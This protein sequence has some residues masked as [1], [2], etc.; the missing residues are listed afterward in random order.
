[1]L[2]LNFFITQYQRN[3]LFV[4][5]IEE[6]YHKAYETYN[7]YLNDQNVLD[8]SD[9]LFQ[10]K[11]LCDDPD[12]R[13]HIQGKFDLVCVDEYQDCNN[14][15]AELAAIFTEPDGSLVVVGDADQAI[16]GFQ[17]ANVNNILQF[18]QNYVNVRNVTLP[19][20]FRSRPQIVNMAKRLIEHNDN[21]IYKPMKAVREDI[22]NC[23]DIKGLY[24]FYNV[25]NH[26]KMTI[27]QWNQ[28]G[29]NYGDIAILGRTNGI[30]TDFYAELNG[31]VPCDYGNTKFFDR[32]EIKD[33]HAYMTYVDNDKDP[34]AFKRISKHLNGVGAKTVENI[35]GLFQANLTLK[36]ILDKPETRVSKKARA[37]LEEFDAVMTEIREESNAKKIMGQII[38]NTTIME[39][40]KEA[41]RK[42]NIE[43]ILQDT[44]EDI[45]LEEY[46]KELE[47]FEV[48][49]NLVTLSTFH[50]AK[51]NEWKRCIIVGVNEGLIPHFREDDITEERRCFYVG[52]TRAEDHLLLLYDKDREPSR[53]LN[54]CRMGAI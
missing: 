18:H 6:Q 40:I 44:D 34:V 17:G 30:L 50:K 46:F 3:K 19:D 24:G 39:A 52:M 36:E 15:Q 1:M 23:V 53:F 43:K 48:D 27:A 14:L 4:E 5:P 49:S 41:P 42:S 54:E 7:K 21:R 38:D 25:A 32:M 31:T 12:I 20:N 35:S 13:T 11:N 8:Y 29:V 26:I 37:S 51:G 33:L 9:L 28:D 16:M 45:S 2:I 10:I 22:D 47:H